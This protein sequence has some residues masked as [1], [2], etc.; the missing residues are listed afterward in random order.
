VIWT[1]IARMRRVAEIAATNRNG[2][3]EV[4]RSTPCCL[5]ARCAT[6]TRTGAGAAAGAHGPELYRDLCG[7][8]LMDQHEI[9]RFLR[10]HL[11]GPELG[12]LSSRFNSRLQ[13]A[14]YPPATKT[15]EPCETCETFSRLQ[16]DAS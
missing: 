5:Y 6:P 14:S 4:T 13:V 7:D 15:T 1:P 8:A 9:R 12:S 16:R 2:Y 11:G 3:K 10:V